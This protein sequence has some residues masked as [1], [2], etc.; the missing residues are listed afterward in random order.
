MALLEGFLSLFRDVNKAKPEELETREGVV[1]D[2]RDELALDRSDQELSELA[3]K[4]EQKWNESAIKKEVERKRD[5]NEKYWLGDHQTPA[6]KSSGRRELVDNIEFEALETFLPAATRKNPE[7]MVS[8]DG[9]PEGNALARKVSDRLAEL[10]D[11]LRF[12]L[13]IKKAAR[14]WAL[15]Y[16]GCIKLGWSVELNEIAMQVRRPHQ[17]ILDPDAMTDECEYEG[18]YLGEYRTEGA[19]DLIER[20]PEKE[21]YIK[22]EVKEKLGTKLRYIEWWTPDILFWS[23]KGEILGKAKNPHWNYETVTPESQSVDE[24]GGAVAIPAQTLPGRNHFSSRKIPYAMLSVFNLGKGPVDDTNQIEQSLPLQDVINKRQRQI[25]RNADSMNA[26]AVVSGDAFTREQ[27]KQVADALRKGATVWVPRGNINN[28]YKRDTGQPI[29]D[30]IYQSLVDYRNELR[31]IFGTSGLSPAGIKSEETVR[32]K[33]LIRGTDTDRAAPIVDHIEQF[34]DYI[35]NWMVQLMYVYYDSPHN[36]SR[37][38]GVTTIVNS[39]FIRP[40]VVS[41]KEGSLIP[42]DRLT[43]RNEAIDLWGAQAIDPLTLAERLEEP[44]PREFAKRVVLWRLNPAM[45][46]QVYTPEVASAVAPAVPIEGEPTG[47]APAGGP[48][49][50]PASLLGEVPIQ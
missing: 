22:D 43:M 25:D 50:E 8:S 26:G 38:Q 29:P 21:K 3:K 42:K 18:E 15:Y 44:D 5:E 32:G 17:L 19:G 40:L 20:F 33:I 36:V 47:G 37:M 27:A 30:F 24:N 10:A 31:N 13:K 1:S 9:T 12:K 14:H 28:V 35:F 23:M 48:K 45:Y 34:A 49:A 7:P 16:L 39:E 4:W 2:L 11:T 41:V 46:A 6:Q